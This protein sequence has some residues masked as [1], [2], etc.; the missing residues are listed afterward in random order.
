MALAT[1]SHHSNGQ[2]FPRWIDSWSG[3]SVEPNCSFTNTV[4]GLWLER[5][6]AGRRETEETEKTKVGKERR[7]RGFSLRGTSRAFVKE[8]VKGPPTSLMNLSLLLPS[9]DRSPLPLIPSTRVQGGG[10]MTW[11]LHSDSTRRHARGRMEVNELTSPPPRTRLL[12]MPTSLLS[13]THWQAYTQTPDKTVGL[14][15][16]TEP[17]IWRLQGCHGATS[18]FALSPWSVQRSL[19]HVTGRVI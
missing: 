11:D 8:H 6:T 7:W 5:E 2:S 15:A 17:R 3:G 14:N 16:G 10:V 4:P 19:G 9:S 12:P 18:G 1:V 13:H